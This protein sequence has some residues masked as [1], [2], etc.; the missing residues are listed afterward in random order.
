MEPATSL[1]HATA[2]TV[3]GRGVLILGPSGAGKSDLAL[4]AITTPFVHGAELIETRLVSDDQVIVERE[5]ECLFA[6][7]PPTIA[8]KLEVRGIGILAFPFVA[9]A[10]VH[11]VVALRS[12]D[13]IERL[14]EA[15]QTH[16]ILGVS[17]PL[18]AIDGSKP[19][20]AARLVL[21]A[22]RLTTNKP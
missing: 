5:G 12:A 14:P 7:P 15:G 21:A 6:S 3:A 22:L 16:P 10:Q 18:V 11:L 2:V 1:V 17:L 13:V 20:A 9:R 4:R 19:G 8:G